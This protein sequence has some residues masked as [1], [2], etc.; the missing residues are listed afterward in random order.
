M[1]RG[2]LLSGPPTPEHL[3]RLYHELARLGAP[4]VGRPSAWPYGPE[5]REQL[6]AL[7][8]E[9]LRFD[10]RLLSVLLQWLLESWNELNPLALRLE[11]R[12]MR[13]P[14]A[15]AV[16][17]DFAR[18]ASRDDEVHL[19]ADYLSAGWSR[20]D[21][22][23]RFFFETERPASRRSAR[24]LGRNLRP[25]ARWGFIGVERP[26]A[27]ASTKR[28]VGRYD[29]ETRRRI[30]DGLLETRDEVS[31]AA[32][33]DAVDH[34]VSRQQALRDLGGH[35][36]LALSGRGRGATWRRRPPGG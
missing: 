28:A 13:W 25:Y 4:S 16:L 30:L 20:V 15:L 32:Y 8:G 7:A 1:T 34:T 11:M 21:P 10:P 24:R 14:Q 2:G 3:E 12:R 23:E 19:L 17:A 26:V 27:D 33:L 36:G 9:M 35:G 29:R 18:E 31:L 5:T 6:L 22:P